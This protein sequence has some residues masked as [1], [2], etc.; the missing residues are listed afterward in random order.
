MMVL[1]LKDLVSRVKAAL[2]TRTPYSVT[3]WK[4]EK[5]HIGNISNWDQNALDRSGADGAIKKGGLCVCDR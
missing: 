3:Y 4:P 5:T 2:P 1:I